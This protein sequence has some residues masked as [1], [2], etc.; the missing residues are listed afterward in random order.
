M[1]TV[2]NTESSGRPWD[3]HTS[4]K[5]ALNSLECVTHTHRQ[6]HTPPSSNSRTSVALP[7]S[8]TNFSISVFSHLSTR[9]PE[10]ARS[11]LKLWVIPLMKR[12]G[13]LTKKKGSLIVL[14]LF[15][16]LGFCQKLA[17]RWLFYYVAKK[18]RIEEIGSG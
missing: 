8:Y 3:L 17:K 2:R 5:R 13:Q 15:Q 1:H 11:T 6:L 12:S 7:W 10:T 16:K 9:S 18:W 14:Y 4:A